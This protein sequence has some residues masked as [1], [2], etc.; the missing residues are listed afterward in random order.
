[1]LSTVETVVASVA[2]EHRSAEHRKSCHCDTFS[3]IGTKLTKELDAIEDAV[4]NN[5]GVFKNILM[6][7]SV[8]VTDSD[9]DMILAYVH[10][11]SCFG[12][13][14]SEL[15][16]LRR[17]LNVG[18]IGFSEFIAEVKEIHKDCVRQL[19]DFPDSKNYFHDSPCCGCDCG[20]GGSNPTT[21]SKGD[22]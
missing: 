3:F 2:E 12:K 21:A 14:F 5:I 15:S 4:F 11:F 13:F 10:W 16:V 18:F 22:Y 8:S 20:C 1:M 6:N 17:K 9:K 7:E 19:Y